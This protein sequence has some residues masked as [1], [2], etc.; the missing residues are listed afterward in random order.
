MIHDHE[1]EI[2]LSNGLFDE[3]EIKKNNFLSPLRQADDALNAEYSMYR[4]IT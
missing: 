3:K 1:I 2:N 4:D